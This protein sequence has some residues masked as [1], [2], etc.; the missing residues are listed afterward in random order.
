VGVGDHRLHAMETVGLERVQEGAGSSPGG[1]GQAPQLL[2]PLPYGG[3]GV[4]A[5][6]ME[7]SRRVIGVLHV[8][9]L[10]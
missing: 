7:A 5:R 8:G 6:S 3:I 1:P 9:R 10:A 2:L 4:F